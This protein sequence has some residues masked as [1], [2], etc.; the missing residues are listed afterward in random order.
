M[1]R[2]YGMFHE[3][4][5]RISA[6]QSTCCVTPTLAF[7]DSYWDGEQ[8]TSGAHADDPLEDLPLGAFR[9]EFM[10]RNFGVPCEFLVYER[11]PRW[12]FERALA[13]SML[14]DVRVRPC[15][16]AALEKMAPVWNAMSR[17]GV[18]D[19]RW[20][21]YWESPTAVSAQ[22]ATVKVSALTEQP[23]CAASSRSDKPRI[24]RA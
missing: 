12:T 21:P 16:L 24:R 20:H 5:G 4:G 6:H 17:F 9:A 1:Q 23:T 22:P 18:D 15:G 19:A 11:P 7:A 14:H 2:L 8:F 13:V 10:G 3:R